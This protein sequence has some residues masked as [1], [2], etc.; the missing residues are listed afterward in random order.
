MSH[1]TRR[2]ARFAITAVLHAVCGME[3][4][5]LPLCSR[6][7]NRTESRARPVAPPWHRYPE[8]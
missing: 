1:L 6:S 5:L 3:L 8:L 7:L 4:K 2:P